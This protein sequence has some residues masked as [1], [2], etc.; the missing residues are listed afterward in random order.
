MGD[1]TCEERHVRAT[2]TLNLT[3]EAHTRKQVQMHSA[4][5]RIAQAFAHKSPAEFGKLSHYKNIY[6]SKLEET[7]TPV[8]VEEFIQENFCK[9][10][11]NNGQIAEAT[12]EQQNL[13][14]KAECFVHFSFVYSDNQL[15]VRDLQGVGYQLCDPEISTDVLIEDGEVNLCAGN[16]STKAIDE[17][18]SAH[19]CN[20]YCEMMKIK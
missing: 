5:R 11:N 15:M 13:L 3:V 6:F 1:Q 4:A 8:T 18:L 17:F 14:Q 7:D 20:K 9:Y 19:I 2:N 16:L 10:I 12:E